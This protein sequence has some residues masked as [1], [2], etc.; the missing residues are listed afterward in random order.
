MYFW[1]HVAEFEK[2]ILISINASNALKMREASQFCA[3]LIETAKYSMNIGRT[4]RAWAYLLM[5]KSYWD[6]TYKR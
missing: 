3:L 6:H 1:E 4:N 5:A 2:S